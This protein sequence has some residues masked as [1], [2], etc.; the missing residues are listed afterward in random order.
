MVRTPEPF[1]RRIILM[2]FNRGFVGGGIGRKTERREASKEGRRK[3]GERKDGRYSRHG[4]WL[5][6]IFL[7]W[8]RGI[9][10]HQVIMSNLKDES[11]VSATFLLSKEL[12]SHSLWSA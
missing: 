9:Y 10:L 8:G 3:T 11:S 1:Y 2:N 5:R 4:F 7:Q 6:Y 12:G